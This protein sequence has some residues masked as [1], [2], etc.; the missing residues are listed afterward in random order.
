MKER[1]V[2]GEKWIAR[3]PP[4]GEDAEVQLVKFVFVN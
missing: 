3:A 2:S 1:E 4:A